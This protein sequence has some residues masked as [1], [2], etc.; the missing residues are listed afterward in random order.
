M[1]I[2]SAEL[3]SLIVAF[4]PLFTSPTWH[5]AQVLLL[6]AL[7]APG[8]RTVTAC[9]QILG[10]GGEE[11]FQRYHRVLNRAKWC[12]RTAS[13]IML[14]LLVMTFQPFGTL[15]IGAD[16]TIER[17]RGKKISAVG[18][19]RDPVRS[20]QKMIIRCFGLKWLSLSLLVRVPWSSR[21]WALPFLTVLCAPQLPGQP[22]KEF[23]GRTPRRK[24]S[25]PR[26][27]VVKAGSGTPPKQKPAQKKGKGVK[28]KQKPAS[29][30]VATGKT[31]RQH[32]T[33]T[34]R[35]MTLIRLIHRWIPTRVKV[36]VVDGGYAA[37]K[38]AL[39]C[40]GQPNTVLVMRFH[41]DAVMHAPPEAK[42]PKAPGPAPTKG[43][44]LSSP[45]Q[46]AAQETGWEERD[47]PW[48]RGEKKKMKV[49]RQTGLWYT[50]G[51]PPVE[52]QYVI[53]RDPEADPQKRLRDEVFACTDLSAT[54]EQIIEW[55]V[56]RWSVEVVFEEARAHLGME[57]QRQWS[58][59]AINRTTPC[60]LG[61]FSLV[62]LLA[63]RLQ[64][65]G[66]IPVLTTAWYQKTEP[67]FS[68]CLA[69]V[70]KHLWESFYHVKTESEGSYVRIPVEDWN[71]LV[72]CLS[73]V[74]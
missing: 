59:L 15:V 50:P 65:D 9:L 29:P 21:V 41:W 48:Y 4:Q 22:A 34:D 13:M 31:P 64:P 10:L 55:V 30:F 28:T 18:C 38:L 74:V 36:F 1:P 54:P 32:K 37:L 24:K 39:I 72:S 2:Q 46:M 7:L 11:D 40:A 67:T 63:N 71:H 68:D 27:K 23:R 56:M 57:T 51:H 43:K 20:S 62:V 58:A 73:T 47:L 14:G 66:K 61:L 17:R 25:G 5:N 8:K 19:Y 12:G 42:E 44:R 33:S 60:L 45:Q 52:I 16:D 35:L 70:R 3:L 6:G 53:V 69:L 26:K 49:L